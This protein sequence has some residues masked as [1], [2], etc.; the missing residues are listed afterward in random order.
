MIFYEF[1][2]SEENSEKALK[3]VFNRLAHAKPISEKQL[4][5][6]KERLLQDY[7]TM[8]EHSF[9]I[10][11]IIGNDII[12]GN[13]NG[14]AT[15]ESVLREI[16]KYNFYMDK[17]INLKSADV[18]AFSEVEG[19]CGNIVKYGASVENIKVSSINV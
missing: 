2:S 5:I 9:A 6:I 15:Y 1:D 11:N 13:P 4:N 17:L 8:L 12:D 16:R 3:T 14:L 18:A 19:V 10:N 7:V